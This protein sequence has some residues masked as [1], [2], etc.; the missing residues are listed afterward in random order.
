MNILHQTA[1]CA[2]ESRLHKP[3]SKWTRACSVQ[4]DQDWKT[5]GTVTAGKQRMLIKMLEGVLCHL[6]HFTLLP[7]IKKLYNYSVCKVK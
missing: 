7:S 6:T 1:E 2:K 4:F 3:Y 5:S